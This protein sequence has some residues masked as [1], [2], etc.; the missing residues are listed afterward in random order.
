[1]KLNR[2][3]FLVFLMILGIAGSAAAQTFKFEFTPRIGYTLSEGFGVT[4]Q[5]ITNQGIVDKLNPKNNLSWG[6]TFDYLASDNFSL[7]FLYDQQLTKLEASFIDGTGSDITDMD[8]LNYH[9]IFTYNFGAAD[10]KVRPFFFGGLGATTYKPAQFKGVDLESKTQFSTTWG[11]GIKFFASP[12]VGFNIGARWTPTY[13]KSDP[14]GVWCNPYWYWGCYVVAE[15]D[16]S[17]QGEFSGGVTLR[18]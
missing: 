8:V 15:T 16:Y 6:L 14:A 7:G 4:E 13:I 12:H 11:G 3:A 18:F 5:V 1:M 9:G 2:M 10:S 17:N